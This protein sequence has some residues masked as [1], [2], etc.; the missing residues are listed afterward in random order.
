MSARVSLHG[1]TRQSR[2]RGRLLLYELGGFPAAATKQAGCSHRVTTSCMMDQQRG[3]VSDGSGYLYGETAAAADRDRDRDRWRRESQ[4]VLVPVLVP[5]PCTLV[6]AGEQRG[7]V[8]GGET[9]EGEVGASGRV[10]R[11]LLPSVTRA[12]Q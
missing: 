7:E 8:G 1:R 10:H 12:C 2:K 3:G 9:R 5:L 6:G 11:S 4:V